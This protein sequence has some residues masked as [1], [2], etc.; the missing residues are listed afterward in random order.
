M[1][2]GDLAEAAG[3]SPSYITRLLNGSRRPGPPTVRRLAAALDLGPCVEDR[4]LITLGHLPSKA[5]VV[6][7][8][9]RYMLEDADLE[10]FA[11]PGPLQRDCGDAGLSCPD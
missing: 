1:T 8:G 5:A 2:R 10:P 4:L 3:L 7:L 11:R 9:M 6:A